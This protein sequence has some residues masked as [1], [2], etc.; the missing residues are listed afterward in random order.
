MANSLIFARYGPKVS[1]VAQLSEMP[2]MQHVINQVT[3]ANGLTDGETGE[4]PGEL[5]GCPVG[6]LAKIQDGE[7]VDGEV[8]SPQGGGK[9]PPEMSSEQ[10]SS[11][12][13]KSGLRI[14]SAT[15]RQSSRNLHGAWAEEI[16]SALPY[17]A[18]ESARGDQTRNYPRGSVLS[19]KAPF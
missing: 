12:R 8:T 18:E 15:G 7:L 11:T 4:G 2:H 1:G 17:S 3:A 16:R 14:S 10:V 5:A 13:R 9:P 6:Y 19:L